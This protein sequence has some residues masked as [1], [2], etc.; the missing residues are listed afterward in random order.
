MT[1]DLTNLDAHEQPSDQMRA[2][3]KS[4]AKTE[5]DILLREGNIDDLSLSEKA[6]EFQKSGTIP[7]EKI[8][9]AFSCLTENDPF[10][11]QVEDDA[12]IYHHPIIPGESVSCLSHSPIVMRLYGC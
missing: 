5:K 4:F 2:I 6:A 1:A 10:I 8:R 9:Q 3:W 12:I 7:A 11:S